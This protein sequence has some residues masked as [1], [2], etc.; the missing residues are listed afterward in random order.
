MKQSMAV[1]P[2]IDICCMVEYT[3]AAMEDGTPHALP[4][5]IFDVD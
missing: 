5:L 2:H 1:P 4:R 3:C